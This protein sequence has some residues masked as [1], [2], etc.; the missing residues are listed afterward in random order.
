MRAHADH[1]IRDE[2][3]DQN[4]QSDGVPRGKERAESPGGGEHV[5]ARDDQ[6][7]RLR[8]CPNAYPEPLVVGEERLD[9]RSVGGSGLQSHGA[10]QTYGALVRKLCDSRSAGDGARTATV[11][12]WAGAAMTLQR[13]GRMSTASFTRH[14]D[15]NIT[16]QN[17]SASPVM[18]F[19]SRHCFASARLAKRVN[20]SVTS[21][22]S[23]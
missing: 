15:A 1:M 12:I 4:D 21:V 23:R 3:R 16:D 11:S 8:R 13:S 22:T 5:V 17:R 18:P 19:A 10:T 9:R 20:W 14:A 2:Q 6:R 7:R